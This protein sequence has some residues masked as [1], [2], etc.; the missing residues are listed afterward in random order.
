MTNLKA[1][2][3]AISALDSGHWGHGI[4]EAYAILYEA[5]EQAK[6][7]LQQ[8]EWVGLTKEEA[9]D[10]WSTEAVKTWH[11]LEAKLKEKNT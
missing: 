1:M 8:R 2:Q 6:T 4:P 9:A 7:Q 11:A 5:I 3:S 10:C